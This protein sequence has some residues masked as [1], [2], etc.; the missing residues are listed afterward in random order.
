LYVGRYVEEKAIDVLLGGYSQYRESVE[1]P[2]P[3]ACCGTGPMAS[4]VAGAAGVTDLGFVQ[5][6]EL[7]RILLAHGAFVFVSRFEPWGVALAEA[8][9][10]GLPAICSEA[11]GVSVELVRHLHNG[12]LVP[13]EDAGAVAR[14]MGWMHEHYEELPEMG[15]RARE[16]AIP[17]SAECWARRWHERFIRLH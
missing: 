6:A 15:R 10:S 13:T 17:Y 9:A 7:P 16:F 1:N 3:L 14:G 5:P 2:W 11:C 12:L 4:A 8:M